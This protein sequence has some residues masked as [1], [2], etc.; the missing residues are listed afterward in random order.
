MPFLMRTFAFLLLAIFTLQTF[1]LPPV[2]QGHNAKTCCGRAICLCKHA[3]DAQC[4]FHHKIKSAK[5]SCH[6]HKENTEK[7]VQPIKESKSKDRFVFSKAP[8]A[9][10]A[11]KSIV[12]GYSKDFIFPSSAP[13]FRLNAQNFHRAQTSNALPFIQ[14]RGIYRPPKVF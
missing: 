12:P 7:A 4:P 1:D 6:L 3:K 5:P 10:D 8:C 9:S 11:P 13:R 14:G 2:R